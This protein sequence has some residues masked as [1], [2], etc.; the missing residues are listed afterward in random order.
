MCKHLHVY[1][2]VLLLII[3]LLI[4]DAANLTVV[5]SCTKC[6]AIEVAILHLWSVSTSSIQNHL[7]WCMQLPL[8]AMLITLVGTRTGGANLVAI[9]CISERAVFLQ[10]N[11]ANQGLIY[12]DENNQ[13]CKAI[14]L[15]V[16]KTASHKCNVHA[17]ACV[18][19]CVVI[20]VGHPR[21]WRPYKRAHLHCKSHLFSAAQ[22][23]L[24][25]PHLII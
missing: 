23:D 18:Y 15:C 22:R 17:P 25:S 6:A 3:L 5:E 1:I 10:L 2:L 11:A 21:R 16:N 4:H 13:L 8:M 12:P 7:H 20:R 14:W 19:A 9:D 24:E